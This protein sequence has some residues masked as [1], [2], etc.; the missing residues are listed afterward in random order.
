MKKVSKIL[1]IFI[2]ILLFLT[3]NLKAETNNKYI[4]KVI[5]SNGHYTYFIALD[6]YLYLSKNFKNYDNSYD[7]TIT[8]YHEVFG[9]NLDF[10]YFDGYC[11]IVYIED[12]KMF[13]VDK[14]QKKFELIY[15]NKDI[16]MYQNDKFYYK[17]ND[18]LFE[19]D[20]CS[21]KSKEIINKGFVEIV[22]SWFGSIMLLTS[23]ENKLILKN[24]ISYDGNTEIKTLKTFDN[25]NNIRIDKG[26]Y[27]NSY[28][29]EKQLNKLVVY[30]VDAGYFNVKEIYTDEIN[31]EISNNF[32]VNENYYINNN[33]FAYIPMKNTIYSDKKISYLNSNNMT[34]IEPKFIKVKN[35]DL[36]EYYYEGKKLNLNNDLEITN[37]IDFLQYKENNEIKR[38]DY[39]TNQVETISYPFE[40]LGQRGN[41]ITGLSQNLLELHNSNNIDKIYLK[42]FFN[43][44]SKKPFTT[45]QVTI[46]LFLSA[47]VVAVFVIS[48][49]KDY[50]KVIFL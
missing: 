38:Y 10:K 37:A 19:Y 5:A 18:Q 42:V 25:K 17:N 36:Y 7:T 2:T 32:F 30:K 41:V 14:N 40:I 27:N 23:E 21:G 11:N 33:F 20:Y 16:I 44:A 13:Y 22:S 47:S 49:K 43:N 39:I 4:K 31:T 8:K 29:T 28:I 50:D 26:A 24:Y 15:Q 3:I 46:I 6:G 1:L 35:N 12:K 34:K 9:F 48:L 45:L